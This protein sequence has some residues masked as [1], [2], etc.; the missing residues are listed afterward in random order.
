MRK[1]KKNKFWVNFIS[2][3]VAFIIGSAV[4]DY[5]G[6]KGGVFSLDFVLRFGIL[7]LNFSIMK[8]LVSKIIYVWNKNKN[9]NK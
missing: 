5:F 8:F 4:S 9:Y 7:M 6:L 2:W 3:F 1:I